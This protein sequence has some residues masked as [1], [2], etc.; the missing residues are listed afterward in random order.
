MGE[1]RIRAC[2]Y[3]WAYCDGDCKNCNKLDFIVTDHTEAKDN[4]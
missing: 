3:G 2:Q 4:V 1:E